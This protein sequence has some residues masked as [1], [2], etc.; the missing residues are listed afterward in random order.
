MEQLFHS[1]VDDNTDLKQVYTSVEENNEQH[2]VAFANEQMESL[3]NEVLNV[4]S[5]MSISL[6]QLMTGTE[7]QLAQICD[8]ITHQGMYGPFKHTTRG[9][10]CKYGRNGN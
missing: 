5:E 3:L 8:E 9:H 10:L 2:P 1:D 4:V 7:R 6:D